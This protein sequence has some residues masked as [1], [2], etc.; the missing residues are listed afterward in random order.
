MRIVSF[1]AVLS[2]AVIIAFYSLWME[3]QFK[4]AVNYSEDNEVDKENSDNRLLVARLGFILA[5]EVNH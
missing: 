2:N 4:R 3:R 1:L 5:F